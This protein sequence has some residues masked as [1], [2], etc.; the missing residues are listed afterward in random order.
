MGGRCFTG[1]GLHGQIQNGRPPYQRLMTGASS[2][3]LRAT[4]AQNTWRNRKNSV[5]DSRIE[6]GSVSTQARIML[7]IVS[8]CRPEPFAAMVPATPDDSTWVV[9]TGRPNMSAAPIVVIA[10]S[11]A[12]APWA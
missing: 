2:R 9:L 5:P 6:A 3:E 10:T 11:S 12:D 7:R 8:H 4:V 1:H